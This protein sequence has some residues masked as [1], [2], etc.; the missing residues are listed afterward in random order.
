MGRAMTAAEVAECLNYS[1]RRGE[2]N[3]RLV[4]RLARAAADK[5]NGAFPEPINPDLDA[6]LWRWAR[7]QV[8]AYSDGHWT[9]PS[10]PLRGAA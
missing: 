9:T 4:Y 6:R 10:S 8:E 3:T 2:P 1:T 5:H 7:T